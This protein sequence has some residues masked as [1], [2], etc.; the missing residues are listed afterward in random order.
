MLVPQRGG[1]RLAVLVGDEGQALAQQVDDAG[2]DR[3]LREDCSGA[4]GREAGE[5]MSPAR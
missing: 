4:C 1:H 5:K 2:L 3:G